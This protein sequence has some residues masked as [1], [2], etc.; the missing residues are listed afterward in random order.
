MP[1]AFGRVQSTERNWISRHGQYT[2]CAH[3]KKKGG[4]G[5]EA[6]KPEERWPR[7]SRGQ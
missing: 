2:E 3:E 6:M 1:E 5:K 7:E 4:K